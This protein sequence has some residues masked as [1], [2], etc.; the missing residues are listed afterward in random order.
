PGLAVV[1]GGE[2]IARV[3][4]AGSP[5]PPARMSAARLAGLTLASVVILFLVGIGW[6]RTLFGGLLHSRDRILLAPAVGLGLTVLGGTVLNA[7]GIPLRGA[8]AWVILILIGVAGL[9]SASLVAR[10]PR[11]S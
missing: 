4:A 2:Q 3:R 10:A 5:A 6:C 8:G 11:S 7:I 9:A 1:S